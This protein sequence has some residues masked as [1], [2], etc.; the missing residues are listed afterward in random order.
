MFGRE[1]ILELCYEMRL[2]YKG[3]ASYQPPRKL[4][5]DKKSVLEYD[6]F[7][8]SFVRK[9]LLVYLHNDLEGG[10]DTWNETFT[11][12]TQDR[13]LGFNDNN[14]N[15]SHTYDA[16]G[17]ITNNSSVGDYAYGGTSYQQAELTLNTAGQDYYNNFAKQTIT[18]N[19][20]KSPVEIVEEGKDRISFQYNASQGRA[21]MYY[22][23]TQT[24]KLQ[25]RYRRFYA[26]DGSMEITF[27]ALSNKTPLLPRESS[28]V[29][30]L[31]MSKTWLS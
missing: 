30:V 15:R 29:V 9:W 27:D 24:D 31:F 5:A 17:R 13:L 28:R 1:N 26:A 3:N 10:A 23:G 22:G 20:F 2:I 4:T 18:Y 11:Y 8:V 12:D 7:M 14:G 21:A 6:C 16:R 19:A 25:R